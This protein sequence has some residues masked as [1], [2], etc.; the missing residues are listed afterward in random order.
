MKKNKLKELIWSLI[1]MALPILYALFIYRK[2]PAQMPVHFS[3]AGDSNLLAAKPLVVFG[4]PI[5]MMILQ[6]FIYWTTL[7]KEI[8]NKNFEKFVRWVFP[9]IFT[10]L[11]LSMIYRSMNEQFDIRKIAAMVVGLVFI[12]VGNYL[13][14]KVQADRNSMNR[15]WAHLFVLLGFLTFIVSIFYL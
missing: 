5:L 11:Y 13:P 4:L 8:L 12:I 1:L 10:V 7:T 2:L 9:V 14:K 3:M 6:I 15:K